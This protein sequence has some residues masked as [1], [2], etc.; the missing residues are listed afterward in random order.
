MVSRDWANVG[1]SF[2]TPPVAS[3]SRATPTASHTGTN[4]R[5]SKPATS[6]PRST[7]ARLFAL[8]KAPL[9][10]PRASSSAPR[11]AHKQTSL[12]A[13]A[14]QATQGRDKKRPKRKS[15]LG[16]RE[17]GVVSGV[18]SPR[19]PAG[20]LSRRGTASLQVFHDDDHRSLDDDEQAEE[21]PVIA[22]TNSWIKSV[23]KAK[24]A[25]QPAAGSSREPSSSCSS[26]SSRTRNV[27]REML[28][29]PSRRG[30]T[31]EFDRDVDADLSYSQEMFDEPGR[32]KRR[33]IEGSGAAQFGKLEMCDADDHEGFGS[34]EKRRRSR[35]LSTEGRPSPAKSG[36]R[37]PVLT[38]DSGGDRWDGD[39]TDLKPFVARH[40]SR[41]VPPSPRAPSPRKRTRATPPASPV[42]LVPPTPSPTSSGSSAESTAA[43]LQARLVPQREPFGRY[44][45]QPNPRPPLQQGSSSRPVEV[46]EPVVLV[47]E[48]DPPEPSLE[49]LESGSEP[50]TLESSSSSGSGTRATLVAATTPR[51][52]S[53]PDSAP[54][55]VRRSQRRGVTSR[56]PEGGLAVSSD[57]ATPRPLP[58]ATIR[59]S[60]HLDLTALPTSS[61]TIPPPRRVR[62]SVTG[63]DSDGNEEGT[64]GTGA[65]LG[66]TASGVLMPPPPL[67]I[68]P[69]KRQG[70]LRKGAPST[71]AADLAAAAAAAEEDRSP[72]ETMLDG[73]QYLLPDG[74][75]GLG[76][77][78]ILVAD[79]YPFLFAHVP[80]PNP[81]KGYTPIRFDALGDAHLP[82][83]H[84]KDS[85]L[86]HKQAL[87]PKQQPTTSSPIR[88]HSAVDDSP[89]ESADHPVLPGRTDRSSPT[90]AAAVAPTAAA[91]WAA[92]VGSAWE[93]ARPPSPNAPR[94]SRLGEFFATVPSSHPGAADEEDETQLVEDSQIVGAG[95]AADEVALLR[96]VMQLRP[97]MDE[98]RTATTPTR[99]QRT[100]SATEEVASGLDTVMEEEQIESP[101]KPSTPSKSVPPLPLQQQPG[102][103]AAPSLSPSPSQYVDDSDPEGDA[104]ESPFVAGKLRS[105]STSPTKRSKRRGRPSWLLLSPSGTDAGDGSPPPPPK[106]VR[107]SPTK[108]RRAAA[109]KKTQQE[110]DHRAGNIEPGRGGHPDGMEAPVPVQQTDL[111][112]DTTTTSAM[113][114]ETT[115]ETQWESYWSY[116]SQPADATAA[117]A[118]A[119]DTNRTGTGT[120]V[121]APL[122]CSPRKLA[123][124]IAKVKALPPDLPPDWAVDEHGELYRLNPDRWDPDQYPVTESLLHVLD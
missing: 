111:T 68:S 31:I 45:S 27:A 6:A 65:Q 93:G 87:E 15:S 35:R 32:Q 97:R 63:R 114:G 29:K 26:A 44:D 110:L 49:D 105:A 40:H 67:P 96:A 18:D 42:W 13:F 2:A 52:G 8:D 69:Q 17:R 115:G 78:P 53:A 88:A 59:S 79:S 124:L 84:A 107:Y 19:P 66:R 54:V 72:P 116:P 55:T 94:Q 89:A 11:P 92:N 101:S 1:Q 118:A 41:P 75:S 100:T 16:P 113:E 112:R 74:R 106:M 83:P 90:V 3:T 64:V 108:V 50:S 47:P 56:V 77:E 62:P 30:P 91:S 37:R 10:T 60:A 102:P 14:S 51:K 46:G 25:P 33:R 21:K 95:P 104:I 12:D 117:V 34:P 103:V 57:D 76:D 23:F 28:S 48:S 43:A 70:R 24:P 73:T 61:P 5:S 99:W 80:R 98:M 123:E 20:P 109:A 121:A 85:P 4:R 36:K 82:T 7:Q 86:L 58:P 39:T 120:E 22:K 9:V 119:A 122:D 38:L 71:R 81:A